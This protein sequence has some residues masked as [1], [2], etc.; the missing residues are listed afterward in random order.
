M[1]DGKLP[2]KDL[3]RCCKEKGLRYIAI[4]D[5]DTFNG[6]LQVE[7]F[8]DEGMVIIPGIEMSSFSVS[9]QQIHVTGYFPSSTD[10]HSFQNYLNQFVYKMRYNNGVVIR[11]RVERCKRI[12]S[13]MAGAGYTVPY[14]MIEE[15][16]KQSAPSL[17]IIAEC[18]VVELH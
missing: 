14:S 16:A 11:N 7:S 18:L 6:V 8:E 3:L 9:E 1:S 10:F 13:K 4:T 12:L 2:V 15:K 17:P 5:H